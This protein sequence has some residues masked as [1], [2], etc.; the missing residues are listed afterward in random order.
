[1]RSSKGFLIVA[2]L[3][4]GGCG[5][6]EGFS[7]ESGAWVGLSDKQKK[8]MAQQYLSM[9]PDNLLN[10]STIYINRCYG[11]L[12]VQIVPKGGPCEYYLSHKV[13]GCTWGARVFSECNNTGT[14][15]FQMQPYEKLSECE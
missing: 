12:G 13:N 10:G 14:C 11:G 5:G 3:V 7:I 1:M 15:L 9:L 4:L 2:Y 6:L 8:D